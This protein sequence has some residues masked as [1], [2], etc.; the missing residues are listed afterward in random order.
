MLFK[1][2]WIKVN[3]EIEKLINKVVI[4]GKKW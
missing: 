4:S 3:S 2:K 1:G